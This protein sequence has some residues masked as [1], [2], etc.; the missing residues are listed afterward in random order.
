MKII[1]RENREIL[2][3][4]VNS[5]FDLKLLCTS[6]TACAMT[7]ER[8]YMHVSDVG[9]KD[10]ARAR[11]RAWGWPLYKFVHSTSGTGHKVH[12]TQH[13]LYFT[14]ISNSMRLFSCK[15]RL[16]PTPLNGRKYKASVS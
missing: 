12:F 5:V 9:A 4:Y 13:K 1:G 11:A 8:L 16:R 2:L 6:R 14:N 15:D 7:N 3:R 10:K